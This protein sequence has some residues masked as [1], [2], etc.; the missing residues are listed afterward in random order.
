MIEV[1]CIDNT[2]LRPSDPVQ[3]AQLEE[4]TQNPLIL[5]LL[6]VWRRWRHGTA[7]RI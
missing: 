3:L 5:T 2:K 7:E 6:M 1:D 4:N